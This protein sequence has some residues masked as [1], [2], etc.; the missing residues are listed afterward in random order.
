MEFDRND[1]AEQV[2]LFNT[3]S[4]PKRDKKLEQ[5][6]F[7]FTEETTRSAKADN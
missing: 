5:W 6:M 1:H 2:L 3:L 4:T 7:Y